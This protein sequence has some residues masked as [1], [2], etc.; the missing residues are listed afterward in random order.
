M[1]RNTD[2][3]FV[4]LIVNINNDGLGPEAFEAVAACKKI[5]LKPEIINYSMH[6]NLSEDLIRL[7]ILNDQPH[8]DPSGLS[9][10]RIF[11][12]AREIGLKVVMLG[13]GPDEIFWGYPWFNQ[14]LMKRISSKSRTENRSRAYWNNPSSSTRFNWY[15]N[16]DRNK[17][18]N[19]IPSDFSSDPFLTS[20]NPWQRYRAEIVHSYL[21]CNGLRQSDRLAMAS[22]V[23][24]RTPYADS[25]LY[26]WA[27]HNSVEKPTSFDKNEFRTAV[28]LGPLEAT[29]FR[30]KEGFLS[31]MGE[32]FRN[33]S[34]ND[35]AGDSLDYLH[36][37]DLGWRIK[38]SLKFLSPS[39]KYK[40]IMLGQWLSQFD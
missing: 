30:K 1:S 9:Y 17:E 22:S 7:S 39:E 14:E 26:G 34:A 10:L 3:Q 32:W 15:L 28:D 24:P 19:S 27:Q 36:D 21:S 40:I 4:P 35:L 11:E 5:G 16:S 31:S 6:S 12:A 2:R 8:A 37:K 25:R 13:H 20:S 33:P 38:P 29:R 23:E 18:K